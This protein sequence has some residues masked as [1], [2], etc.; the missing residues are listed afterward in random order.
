VLVNPD[1]KA[2]ACKKQI[3]DVTLRELC[4]EQDLGDV[5]LP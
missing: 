2:L 3:N 4:E 5:I 1:S